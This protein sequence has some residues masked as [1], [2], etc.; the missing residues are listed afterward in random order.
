MIPGV[1]ITKIKPQHKPSY[2]VTKKMT[3]IQLFWLSEVLNLLMRTLGVPTLIFP[4]MRFLMLEG[5]MEVL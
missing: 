1:Q 3:M 2:F 5:S 4:G